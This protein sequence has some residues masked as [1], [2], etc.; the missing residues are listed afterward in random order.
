APFQNKRDL[1]IV[2]GQ[3]EQRAVGTVR[4][5]GSDTKVAADVDAEIAARTDHAARAAGIER[6][7]V[8][9]DRVGAAVKQI[10][11]GRRQGKSDCLARLAEAVEASARNGAWRA[12]H[13]TASGANARVGVD[14]DVAGNI[15]SGN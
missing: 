15:A 7:A 9:G 5:V 6:H 8:D 3:R 14:R 11:G 13:A 2:G 4:L 12:D 10:A 1:L